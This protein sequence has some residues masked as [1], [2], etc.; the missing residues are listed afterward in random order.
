MIITNAIPTTQE[1]AIPLPV[2]DSNMGILRMFDLKTTLVTLHIKMFKTLCIR[3]FDA[4]MTSEEL[5]AY[6]VGYALRK[7]IIHE[8]TI[9]NTN[10]NY[11][12]IDIHVLLCM[13]V[14]TRLNNRALYTSQ[15]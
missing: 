7:Y 14:M 3:N 4:S 12:T 1:I 13:I 6:C 9:L 8:K 10:V 5:R 11:D 2:L 15:V